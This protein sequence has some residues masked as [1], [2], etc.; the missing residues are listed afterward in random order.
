MEHYGTWGHNL[1]GQL[2]LSD[3]TYRSVQTQV[4]SASNWI[5][6]SCGSYYT[7]ALKSN[8]TM[9]AWGDGLTG[10][11]GVGDGLD[12]PV[13]TQIGTG[14]NWVKIFNN[15]FAPQNFAITI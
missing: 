5:Q 11:L 3:L 2:G 15:H 9:W 6:I 12:Q 7:I 8:G 10:H 1:Y 13:T 4:G 14:S